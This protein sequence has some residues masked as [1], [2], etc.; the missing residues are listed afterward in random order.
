MDI[1]H[2][3]HYIER[4]EAQLA[5]EW[6]R[7][8]SDKDTGNPWRDI[9]ERMLYHA[10]TAGWQDYASVTN[11]RMDYATSYMNWLN[12]MQQVRKLT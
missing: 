12:Y 1:R 5:E 8:R 2:K 4:L 11:P 3:E 6:R 9:P 7:L 10:F